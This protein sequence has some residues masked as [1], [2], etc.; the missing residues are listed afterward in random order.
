MRFNIPDITKGIMVEKDCE[1]RSVDMPEM[2]SHSY[3]ELYFLLSGKRRYFIGHRIFDVDAGNLVVIPKNELHK[4]TSFGGKGYERY[5][6]YFFDEDIEEI[7]RLTGQKSTEDF[8]NSGCLS[9][10]SEYAETIKKNIMQAEFEK[11]HSD[12]Y[13]PLALRNILHNIILYAMRFGRSTDLETGA[14]ADKIQLAAKYIRE[15]YAEQI[16][17]GEVAG[18]V[19]M[20]ETYFSKKFKTL[21]GCCFKEYLIQ[22]RIKAAEKLLNETDF[23]IGE[24]SDSCGFSSSNY[25][26]DV[27]K[28][29]KGMSPSEY[30]RLNRI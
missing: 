16:S 29:W 15:N 1:R 20:E 19:F 5:V 10:G 18:M 8:L 25:F 24:I 3:H 12:L 30:R 13:T 23:T 27:F 11:N 14:G 28:R 4:T 6:L 22:T 17:L 2:H 26:G 7:Y 21:T 9:F